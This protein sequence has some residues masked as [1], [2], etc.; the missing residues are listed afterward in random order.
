MKTTH[1][2]RLKLDDVIWDEEYEQKVMENLRYCNNLN[3]KEFEIIFL[4]EDL[5]KDDIKKFVERNKNLLS[6]MNVNITDNR[7]LD[8]W[9]VINSDG[10]KNSWRYSYNGNILEGIVQ[11]IKLT[12]HIRGKNK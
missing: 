4:Y 10:E 7:K 1:S 9:F 5:K 12:K 11:Y 8:V 2:L 3:R 6:E